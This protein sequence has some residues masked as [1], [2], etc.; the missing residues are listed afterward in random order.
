MLLLLLF[1]S[2]S[3]SIKHR[4]GG[5]QL[6]GEWLTTNF[7]LLFVPIQQ[8]LLLKSIQIIHYPGVSSMLVLRR[9]RC[10]TS[11][12]AKKKNILLYREKKHKKHRRQ[13]HTKIKILYVMLTIVNRSISIKMP[14]HTHE[15][16][17]L[18]L[19]TV[20]T[21]ANAPWT[22]WGIFIKSLTN[23]SNTKIHI[24]IAVK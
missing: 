15:Q 3:S 12:K 6:S 16:G 19:S 20:A 23:F 22:L 2:S 11:K 18:S 5:S 8:P 4:Y 17:R 1:S 7:G 21:N 10:C 14:I 13:L 24:I 9:R